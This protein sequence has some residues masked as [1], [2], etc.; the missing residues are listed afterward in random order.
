[1]NIDFINVNELRDFK[2]LAFYH[3]KKKLIVPLNLEF[4]AMIVSDG[5]NFHAIETKPVSLGFIFNDLISA[6]NLKT[7]PRKSPPKFSSPRAE[8]GSN[9]PKNENKK[10]E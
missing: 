9:N 2:I 10:T 6:R 7:K 8:R 4:D 1:M 3:S 5:K